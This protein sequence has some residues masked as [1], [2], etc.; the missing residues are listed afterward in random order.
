MLFMDFFKNRCQA[1]NVRDI[2]L[3]KSCGIKNIL[4]NHPIIIQDITF[5]A[6]HRVHDAIDL[7]AF[8]H[9]ISFQ[10]GDRL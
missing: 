5:K 1:P 2:F 3:G 4:I 7:T 9:L 8:Q 6:R 10:I